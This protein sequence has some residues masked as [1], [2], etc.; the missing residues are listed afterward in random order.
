MKQFFIRIDK[1][2]NEPNLKAI[3][4]SKREKML[5]EKIDMTDFMVWVFENYPESEQILKD[6]P[7]Y[8]FRFK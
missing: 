7:N 5:S 2:L 6:N 3:W 8:Q 1:L 4:K